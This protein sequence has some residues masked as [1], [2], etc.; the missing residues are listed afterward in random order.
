M[1]TVTLLRQADSLLLAM[2]RD[3]RLGRAQEEPPAVRGT[4]GS[5][6]WVGPRDGE[7][8]GTWIGA[9]AAGVVACILNGYAEGDPMTLGD[10]DAPSR[11][12]ILVELMERRPEAAWEWLHRIFTPARYPSF[13]MV[14]ATAVDARV[15]SWRPGAALEWGEIGTGWSMLTSSAWR[16]D[17]VTAWRR[18]EFE[19]WR[20]GGARLAGELPAFNLLEVEGREMWSPM[21]TRPFSAT[22]SLTLARSEWA[23]GRCELLY[24]R[25]EEGE[26]VDAA[27]PDARLDLEVESGHDGRGRH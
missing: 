8:G 23:E 9:N 16:T 26:A 18:R 13:T 20:S 14:V 2:N 3:E 1:C 22:R 19:S 21:M 25:R 24:W 15:L 27:A 17:E 6:R 7:A 5:L 10:R 12:R 4:A 11:G